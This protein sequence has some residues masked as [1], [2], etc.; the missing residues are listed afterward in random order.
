[1]SAKSSRNQSVANFTPTRAVN[2]QFEMT[3]EIEQLLATVEEF[4][5]QEQC[6]KA[7]E[8]LRRSKSGSP[9]VRNA[10]GV[11]LLRQGEIQRAI[12]LFRGLVLTS[13]S[14]LLRMDVPTV[15]QTNFATALLMAGNVSGCQSALHNAESAG[16]PAV[17][18]LRDAIVAWKQSLNFW[19]RV[20]WYLGA[21][22]EQPIRLDF[23]PGDLR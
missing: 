11:C 2:D 17:S 6:S 1:M 9:W 4:L 16:H 22:P 13:G 10:L 12:E 20:N 15:F 8:L 14:I 5:Q 7:I 23:P 18:R 21:Q 3:A 19:Q